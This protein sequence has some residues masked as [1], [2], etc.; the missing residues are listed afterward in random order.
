MKAK[1]ICFVVF[2]ISLIGCFSTSTINTQ[3]KTVNIPDPNL[4]MAVESQLGKS[5]GT[6]ITSSEMARLLLLDASNRRIKTLAGLEHATNLVMLDLFENVISDISAL[7]GL[8]KLRML[9]LSHNSISDISALEGLT[10]LRWLSLSHN[11]I[12][13]I[14]ALTGLTK[15]KNLSVW[16]NRLNYTSIKTHIPT[17]EGRKI[18]VFHDLRKPHRLVIIS[19]DDQQGRIGAALENPYVVEVRDLFQ[20][21]F[22]GVPVTFSVTAGDGRLSVENATT[23]A[24]GR[25]E[26]TLTLGSRAGPNTV[27]VSASDVELP[28]KFNAVA[29]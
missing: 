27:S 8:T 19:G 12:S 23:D 15:L 22:E 7:E 2:C 13:D 21:A 16:R 14:S 26:A 3:K 24:N 4:R 6:P 9:G 20:N 29:Y 1:S 10:E 28:V 18:S 25:A 5:A 17:L 11:S